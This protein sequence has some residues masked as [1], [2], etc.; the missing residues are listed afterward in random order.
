M[1]RR[2]CEGYIKYP[3]TKHRQYDYFDLFP[4]DGQPNKIFEST[5]K[6]GLYP[7]LV[8]NNF[9]E[10]SCVY[11]ETGDLTQCNGLNYSGR[12]PKHQAAYLTGDGVKEITT[13]VNTV[14]TRTNGPEA[15][16]SP[17]SEKQKLDQ[18]ASRT[19]KVRAVPVIVSVRKV[20]G[21]SSTY[22]Q[23]SPMPFTENG[24]EVPACEI[25]EIRNAWNNIKE[26]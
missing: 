4:L 26:N 7:E 24:A 12:I 3:E 10:D 8:R 19:V 9:N 25:P 2:F 5:G 20:S 21:P 17:P 22:K 13:I 15:L 23:G 18:S 11:T 16:N 14:D 6:D 1:L